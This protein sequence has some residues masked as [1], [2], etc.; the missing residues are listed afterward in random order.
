MITFDLHCSLGHGFEGWF[1]S[2]TEYDAQQ[3]KGLL[4]CPYCDDAHVEKSLSAPN[5]GRKGNLPE[6]MSR[7]MYLPMPRLE[8]RLAAK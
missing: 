6:R 1:S 4:R 7:N 8:S 2:S 3:L 5:I